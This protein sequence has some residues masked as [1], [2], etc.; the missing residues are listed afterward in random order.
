MQHTRVCVTHTCAHTQTDV[1]EKCSLTWN[2]CIVPVYSLGVECVLS[3]QNVFSH[4]R[5]YSLTHTQADLQ[6]K[7]KQTDMLLELMQSS[8][9]C[10]NE[11][12]L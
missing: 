9:N 3:L 6:E 11:Q 5:M 8:D 7:E 2:V 12:V 10:S 4:Y 1:Q